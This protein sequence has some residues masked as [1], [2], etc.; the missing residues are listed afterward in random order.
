MAQTVLRAFVTMQRR[1]D[2]LRQT[3]F[4]LS[5]LAA[6]FL[7]VTVASGQEAAK[8]DFADVSAVQLERLITGYATAGDDA[9]ALALAEALLLKDPDNSLAHFAVANI[10]LRNGDYA[11]AQ[12]AAKLA[13]R[14]AGTDRQR[15]EAARISAIAALRSE[16]FLIAQYWARHTHHYA[17]SQEY[18]A[19]AATDFRRLRQISPWNGS[20]RFGIRPTDNANGGAEDRLNVIDGLDVIGI[21]S[22]DA[23]A[24]P[25]TIATA[26]AEL[27]YRLEQSEN[28]QT[29]VG[30]SVYGRAVELAG[31]PMRQQVLP[32]IE[33][34]EASS[35]IRNSDYS[36]FAL[37]FGAS[38]QRR[39]GKENALRLEAEVGQHWRGGEEDYSYGTI[40]GNFG[41]DW[42]TNTWVNL[43]GSLEA[44]D[45]QNGQDDEHLKSFGVALSK[46]ISSG[47][48]TFSIGARHVA[49]DNQNARSHGI[50]ATAGYEPDGQIGPVAFSLS[51]G[52]GK[53]TYPDY[54]VLIFSPPGG[55][56]DEVLSAEIALWV[57]EIGYAALLPELRVQL[58]RAH[59]N[60]S[61][62]ERSEAAVS[63]GIRS[64]F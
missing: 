27:T 13:F 24:L 7:N 9:R 2:A 51:A 45:K 32:G 44:R 57:P 50:F 59:S 23:V 17:P 3:S 30:V 42:Q 38:H 41:V 5:C 21:L 20:L 22:D 53:T 29:F 34:P 62:F 49:S 55:R 56:Q 15:Y 60:I 40:S 58:V 10:L 52:V 48:L 16:R 18:K 19:L 36:Q 25:G 37:G 54:T 47:K 26:N 39:V 14:H 28:G 12:R 8:V 1:T 6:A 11:T 46:K 61:R 43:W 33:S 31:R 35:E 64:A 4:G 63:F